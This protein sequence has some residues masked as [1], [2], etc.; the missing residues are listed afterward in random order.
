MT[1][2]RDTAAPTVD[3]AVRIRVARLDD[4]EAIAASEAETARTPG[5][6]VGWPGEIPLAVYRDMIAKLA[7]RGRYLVAVDASTLVG[8]ALLDPMPMRGNAH[9]FKLNIIVR[10]SWLGHGIGTALLSKLLAWAQGDPRVGKVELNVRAGN[11]RAQR[12]YRQFGFVQEARFHRRVQRLDGIY[13][14]DLGMAWFPARRDD[15]TLSTIT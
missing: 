2:T 7:T 10:P 5:L 8:H 4:A 3:P 11:L 9:V 6:L 1:A 14:D 13:E 12:L 15:D